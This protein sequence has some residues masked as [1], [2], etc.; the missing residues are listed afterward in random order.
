MSD[1]TGTGTATYA[2]P[3]Y[4]WAV[5][6]ALMVALAVSL[7]DR[8]L[9]SLVVQP[10]QRDLALSDVHIGLLNGLSFVIFY[11]TFG[12]VMGRL[13]DR[14]NRRNLIVAG[15]VVW[16]LATAA[17]GFARTFEELFAARALVGV[18]EAVLAPCAYSMIADYFP[19]ESRARAAGVYTT[20]MY[21]GPG[22]A[23]LLGGPLVAWLSSI[24]D[25]ALPLVGPLE[26]WQAAFILVGL[27]GLVVGAVLWLFVK[28]PPRH[29]QHGPGASLGETFRFFRSRAG[30]LAILIAGFMMNNL[31]G[32]TLNMW[33]PTFYIRAFGWTIA[34]IGLAYGIILFLG[35]IGLIAGGWISDRLTRKGYR[36]GPLRAMIWGVG[37]L[38]PMAV[39]I[40]LAPTVELSLFA[41]L[42][43]TMLMG[44]PP[45]LGPVTLYQIVP[46]NFRGQVIA[47]L[48]FCST[49]LGMSVGP[50][51]VGIFTEGVFNDRQALGP[52]LAIVTG[53]SGL[54]SFLCLF[55]ARRFIGK[56]LLED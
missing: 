21:F 15:M 17:C 9:L 2:R 29:E 12:L 41:L 11:A 52:A 44:L 39:L 22:I 16:C 50:V 14:Y 19:K 24:P 54:G 23:L 42:A 46:N 6:G 30:I 26:A 36:D 56:Y 8:Q 20:G 38:T 35:S 1:P 25:L 55:T 5:V 33:V 47:L 13:A 49:G 40:G 4:A 3:G 28:E 27:P 31:V 45:A 53:L 43:V 48:F 51:L 34:D 32:M 18:G 37:L 7:M 10:I